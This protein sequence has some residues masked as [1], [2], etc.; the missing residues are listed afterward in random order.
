MKIA[1]P[2]DDATGLI[3]EEYG[4]G[5]PSRP[6]RPGC[7]QVNPNEPVSFLCKAPS[8]KGALLSECQTP[9]LALFGAAVKTGRGVKRAT[10]V[11]DHD[12]ARLPP[13]PYGKRR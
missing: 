13:P 5:D 8:P 6:L 4:I 10:V 9:H 1:A 12:V 3:Q 2:A 7:K 11:P